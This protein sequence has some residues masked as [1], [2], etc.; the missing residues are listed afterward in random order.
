M[1]PQFFLY[2]FNLETPALPFKTPCGAVIRNPSRQNLGQ[3]VVKFRW[4][5]GPSDQNQIY[6]TPLLSKIWDYSDRKKLWDQPFKWSW[7]IKFLLTPAVKN[8]WRTNQRR[9]TW[10]GARATCLYKNCY[11]SLFEGPGSVEDEEHDD[12]DD[13]DDGEV[14]ILPLLART[15]AAS[16]LLQTWNFTIISPEMYSCHIFK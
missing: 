12:G 1:V 8:V 6:N 2:R 16:S 4:F 13:E 10:V 15:T 14:A 5:L 9:L 3:K 7:V 11:V